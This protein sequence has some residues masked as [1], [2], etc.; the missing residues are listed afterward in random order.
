[1]FSVTY[2]TTR[3]VERTIPSLATTLFNKIRKS[4]RKPHPLSTRDWVYGVV[5]IVLNSLDFPGHIGIRIGLSSGFYGTRKPQPY[6]E[7]RNLSSERSDLSCFGTQANGEGQAAHTMGGNYSNCHRPTTRAN[8]DTRYRYPRLGGY[9]LLSASSLVLP[10][11]IYPFAWRS[12]SRNSAGFSTL[13]S[14]RAV[15]EMTRATKMQI[16]VSPPSRGTLSDVCR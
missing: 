1:V 11:K 12:I 6:E 14:S 13:L 5:D 8:R 2:R 15:A 9:S 16:P 10:R 3:P 4:V 7:V